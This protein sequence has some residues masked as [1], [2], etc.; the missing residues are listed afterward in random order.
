VFT[1]STDVVPPAGRDEG[2]L[3]PVSFSPANELCTGAG[4]V[5]VAD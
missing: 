3:C 1:S 5:V 2:S 4:A